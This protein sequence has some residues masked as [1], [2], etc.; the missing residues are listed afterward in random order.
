MYGIGKLD[1]SSL[2]PPENKNSVIQTGES[3]ED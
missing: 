3:G 2:C 1:R